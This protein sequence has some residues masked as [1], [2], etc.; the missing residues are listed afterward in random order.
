MPEWI[1]LIIG[2]IVGVLSQI[3][4]AR[5]SKSKRE[6]DANVAKDYLTLAKMS[7]DELERRINLITKLD[8]DVRKLENENSDLKREL[9]NMKQDRDARGEQLESLEARV[10]ALNAQT[11]KDA[12]DRDELR[13]KVSDFE[14][15]NRVLWKYLI[16]LI[17]QLK[18]H[19]IKPVAPPDE[20]KS[21]P[22]IMR[23]F[24]D[25]RAGK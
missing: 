21:D 17:E 16:A 20:L 9:G 13:R 7:A 19:D 1:T 8:G 23:L 4:V 2:G 6:Q 24:V 10:A 3:A 11:D 22:E 5:Y 12:R 25:M 15:H 14:K 18:R